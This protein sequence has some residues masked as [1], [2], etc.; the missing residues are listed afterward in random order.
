MPIRKTSV[1]FIIA[2][3]SLA[4]FASAAR[5]QGANKARARSLTIGGEN[6]SHKAAG[7]EIKVL[8]KQQDQWTPVGLSEV[9]R[10]KDRV[11]VEFWSNVSGYVYLV[12]V[13]PSG[14]SKVLYHR[15]IEKDKDYTLP[16]DGRFFEF[17][18]EKGDEVLKLV[19]SAKPIS[20]LEEAIAKRNGLLGESAASA[21]DELSGDG[22]RKAG[23]NVAMVQADKAKGEAFCR[24]LN[25]RSRSLGFEKPNPQKNTGAVV[26]AQPVPTS[27]QKGNKELLGKNDAIVVELRLRHI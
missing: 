13:A 5:A 14:K 17:D 25:C 12:N 8:K 11:K 6:V 9:F 18:E 26:V 16:S 4:L 3:C 22:S 19:M 2:L 1:V 20:V 10:A 27:S 24:A 7:M 15:A 21:S 23:E